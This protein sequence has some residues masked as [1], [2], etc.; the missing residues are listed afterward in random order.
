[1]A[2]KFASKFTD[3][4]GV[5]ETAPNRYESISPPERMGNTANIAYG[6]CALAVAVSAAHASLP[7]TGVYRLYSATGSYLA[8]AFSDRLFSISIR[9]IRDT[10]TFAT[11]Q[12]EV[13]QTLDDGKERMC[14]LALADFQRPEQKTLLT[15]SVKPSLS[16][17]DVESLMNNAEQR[18]QLVE[19]G[20]LHPKLA[21]LNTVV[22]GLGARHFDQRPHPDGVMTQNDYGIAKTVVTSQDDRPLPSKLSSDYV[23]TKQD[24]QT[25]GQNMAALAFLL[26]G[27][28][29]FVPLS[30]D[31]KFLDDAGACSSLEF[32]LRVFS[33]DVEMKSWKLR[34]IGTVVGG[35]G[36]TYSESR[37]WDEGRNLVASMTQQSIL[38]PPPEKK[39]KGKL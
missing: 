5:R 27:A 28:I 33:N 10:V 4:V 2:S 9:K 26:D 35:E 38:R 36:R 18:Q 25:P 16:P 6:G 20:L 8:P 22:F 13:F 12:V 14:L 3:L 30:H 15:Y 11:R 37:L 34:E 31:H 7:S 24:L 29:S 32:A 21:K 19:K 17:V 1:M 39:A 23:K